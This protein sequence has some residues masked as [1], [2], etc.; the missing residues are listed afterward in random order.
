MPY[1]AKELRTVYEPSL[2]AIL[3]ALKNEHP[4]VRA[5]LIGSWIRRV[6]T[7]FINLS[8]D[9]TMKIDGDPNTWKKLVFQSD[10][11]YSILSSK[12]RDRDN[13]ALLSI[14]GEFNYIISYLVWGVSGDYPGYEQ[15]GYGA[16]SYIAQVLRYVRDGFEESMGGFRKINM[17]KG[18]LSDVIDEVYR[19]KTSIYENQKIEE[20][21]D[22]YC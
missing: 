22:L 11:V 4:V 5:E 12:F 2:T 20:N 18:V 8:F 19:R 13:A 10:I 9:D 14:A 7:R 16:R 15:A 17:L 6:V 3:E 1:I 21:G